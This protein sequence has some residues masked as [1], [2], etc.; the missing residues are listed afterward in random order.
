MKRREESVLDIPSCPACG[1][2]IGVLASFKARFDRLTCPRCGTRL[3][4]QNRT[5]TVAV[6]I[7]YLIFIGI[8]RE[9]PGFKGFLLILL[10]TIGGSLVEYL[11]AKI[12]VS[13]RRDGVERL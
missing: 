3:K 6:I 5:R 7:V 13:S 4:I 12:V 11:A 2:L 9:F 10:I 1:Q 8:S